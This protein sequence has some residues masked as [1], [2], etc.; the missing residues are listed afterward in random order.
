MNGQFLVL[1]S[2][3]DTSK[4]AKNLVNQNN[5]I[6]LKSDSKWMKSAMCKCR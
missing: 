4:I 1:N 5:A 6:G 2:M 3:E